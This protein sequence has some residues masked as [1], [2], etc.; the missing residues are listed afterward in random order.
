MASRLH[1]S[2]PCM[3]RCSAL[4]PAAAVTPLLG[5]AVIQAPPPRQVCCRVWLC[6]RQRWMMHVTELCARSLLLL[7]SGTVCVPASEALPLFPPCLP[8]AC[9]MRQV[10]D[11]MNDVLRLH[12]DDTLPM[13]AWAA[14][15]MYAPMD[16]VRRMVSGCMQMTKCVA[17]V[18]PGRGTHGV[19]ACACLHSRRLRH[20]PAGAVQFPHQM[21]QAK[22]TNC[23]CL[24]LELLCGKGVLPQRASG[25]RRWVMIAI[26][27]C[28]PAH[29]PWTSK[30]S[31]CAPPLPHCSPAPPFSPLC[32]GWGWGEVATLHCSCPS[33][34]SALGLS[35][36]MRPCGMVCLRCSCP[37]CP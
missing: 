37:A 17:H 10:Y 20:R 12:K 4:S 13:P 24:T 5:I 35:P 36:S 3:Q 2:P 31:L 7:L 28:L 18:H 15:L 14:K 1:S 11:L 25:R 32:P 26:A 22:I 33:L 30:A 9:S 21:L 16:A 27:P 29:G 6:S 23:K 8:R 34:P 19:R